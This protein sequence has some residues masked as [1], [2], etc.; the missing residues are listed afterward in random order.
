MFTLVFI[1]ISN[2]FIGNY[3]SNLSLSPT[4]TTPPPPLPK[5]VGPVGPIMGPIQG[6][7]TPVRGQ[8]THPAGVHNFLFF[9][10]D[11]QRLT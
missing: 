6:A 5:S 8:R 3:F 7:Q 11:L 4:P 2:W 1:S 9:S 10:C